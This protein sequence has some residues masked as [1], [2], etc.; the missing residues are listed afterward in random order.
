MAE[1]SRVGGRVENTPFQDREIELETLISRIA[2]ASLLNIYG[3][4]GIGKSRLLKQAATQIKAKHPGAVVIQVD[5]Q[6]LPTDSFSRPAALLK[7]IAT[8]APSQLR[9]VWQDTE[10]VAREIVDQLNGLASAAVTPVYLMLDTTESL[11]EDVGFWRWA[12]K[13]LIG[14]LAIEDEVRQVL[15]GRV[16]APWRRYEVRHALQLLPLDP[17]PKEDAAK[18]LIYDV[19]LLNSPQLSPQFA[20]QAVP[21]LLDLS[22]GHPLLSEELAADAASR[23][24]AALQNQDEFRRILS[25]QVVYRF[26]DDFL[27]KDVD[28]KWCQVLRWASV[29]DSFDAPMLHRYVGR[30]DDQLAE[31]PV[32]FF[33]RGVAEM[34]IQ[35]ALVWHEE[36]GYVVHGILQDVLRRN[37]EILDP[38]HY[39]Q[40]CQAAAEVYEEIAHDLAELP[41]ARLYR[42]QA[43][44]YRARAKH[45]GSVE[46]GAQ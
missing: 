11:Q 26:I 29:L 10:Q 35:H 19:L 2:G 15:A 17:L 33:I 7:A 32:L 16:P 24:P 23:L 37:H 14:P 27:F 34:R 8:Q 4:A 42:E 41:E 6:F 40:A 25:E 9:G 46:E 30:L 22:F 31:K 28:S 45:S 38:E 18:Q 39:R 20:L 12:E 43:K 36:Q 5:L 44:K 3:V 13:N 1:T 21:I